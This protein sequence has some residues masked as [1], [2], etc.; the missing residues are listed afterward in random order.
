MNILKLQKNTEYGNK[1]NFAAI[2]SVGEF[3]RI[4]PLTTYENYREVIEDIAKRVFE[5]F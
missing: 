5:K 1:Y 2:A 3:Q 4:H